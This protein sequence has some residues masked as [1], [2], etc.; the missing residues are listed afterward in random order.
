MPYAMAPESRHP[1]SIPSR[2]E[3]E[4][5]PPSTRNK[6][7]HVSSR[8][9]RRTPLRRLRILLPG[10]TIR[11]RGRAAPLGA[12]LHLRRHEKEGSF[13][14]QCNIS[15]S[16]LR[17]GERIEVRGCASVQLPDSTLTLPS[18]LARERLQSTISFTGFT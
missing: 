14:S 13:S 11:S 2:D 10:C 3:A 6:A 16:P 1:L 12:L 18:P 4:I 7:P 17:E 15:T 5:R 9:T 8:C